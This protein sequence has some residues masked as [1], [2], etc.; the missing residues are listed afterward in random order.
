[1]KIEKNDK[2]IFC[3]SDCGAEWCDGSD[4]TDL[5]ES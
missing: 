1:L 3:F 4:R 5:K 2:V